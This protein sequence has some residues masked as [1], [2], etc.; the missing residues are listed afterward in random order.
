MLGFNINIYYEID[1]RT[2]AIRL[3]MDKP[4]ATTDSRYGF[5]DSD[6]ERFS[7]S[8]CDLFLQSMVSEGFQVVTIEKISGLESYKSLSYDKV[9]RKPSLRNQEPITAYRLKPIETAPLF[10]IQK[11]LKM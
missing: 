7:N 9:L 5:I 3:S 2:P 4:K 1:N 8:L 10:L 6:V 11:V